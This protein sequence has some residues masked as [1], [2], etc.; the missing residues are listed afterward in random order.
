[1]TLRLYIKKQYIHLDSIPRDKVIPIPSYEAW[2]N[3]CN[4]RAEV[5]II[6]SIEK[7]LKHIEEIKKRSLTPYTVPDYFSGDTNNI[8]DPLSRTMKNKI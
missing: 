8:K 6:P 4:E 1:M 7:I 3:N 5:E 2:C